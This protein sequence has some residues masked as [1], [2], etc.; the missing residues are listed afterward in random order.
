M[1]DKNI[2]KSNEDLNDIF[3][4]NKS[5]AYMQICSLIIGTQNLCQVHILGHKKDLIN[6]NM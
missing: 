3:F 6:P 4:K 5:E 1:G 2:V